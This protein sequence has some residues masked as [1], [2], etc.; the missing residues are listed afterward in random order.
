[1]T[2][3]EI[4]RLLDLLAKLSE[5]ITDGKWEDLD[6]VDRD[7]IG[8]LRNSLD[9]ELW[10]P[11][12][13]YD[14]TW[15]IEWGQADGLPFMHPDGGMCPNPAECTAWSNPDPGMVQGVRALADLWVRG[16]Q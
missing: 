11:T 10:G 9:D 3:R 12:S 16:N 8:A 6:G 13:E 7:A 4:G 14:W 15:A 2:T 1:M 5:E